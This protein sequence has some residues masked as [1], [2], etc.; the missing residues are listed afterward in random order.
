[1]KSYTTLTYVVV[2]V[3]GVELNVMKKSNVAKGSLDV[4]TQYS[5]EDN[6]IDDV[7]DDKDYDDFAIVKTVTNDDE[8]DKNGEVN[9]CK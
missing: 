9:D 7:D 8:E 3:V 6:S 4:L 1:M 5:D 2:A